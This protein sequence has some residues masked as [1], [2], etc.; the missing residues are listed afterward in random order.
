MSTYGST[1]IFG[2]RS[3]GKVS[4]TANTAYTLLVEP[5]SPFAYTYI[6]FAQ[7]TTQTTAHYI[8]V[9]RPL[10]NTTTGSVSPAPVP[11]SCYLTSATAVSTAVFNVNQNPGVFTAYN[12]NGTFVPRTANVTVSSGDYVAYQ[13]PDG[14]WEVNTVSSISTLAITMNNNISS[15]LALPA[16]TPIFYFGAV[17]TT[18]ATNPYDALKHPQ[19]NLYA[20]SNPTTINFGSEGYPWMGSFNKGQPLLIYCNN[21]T[22]ASTLERLT[23]AYSDRGSPFSW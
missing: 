23:A 10:S 9:A 21:I 3:Y 16:G 5:M 22:S 17:I 15:A 1:P 18:V 8:T 4:A 2:R 13:Y 19:F 6:E 7:F 20:P 11:C 14:T 12:F